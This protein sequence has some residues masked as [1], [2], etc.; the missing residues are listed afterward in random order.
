MPHSRGAFCSVGLQKTIYTACA[1]RAFFTDQ[2]LKNRAAIF[3]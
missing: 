1:Q 2:P 3:Q